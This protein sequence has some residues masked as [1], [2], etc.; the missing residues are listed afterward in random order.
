MFFHGGRLIYQALTCRLF[1]VLVQQQY[2]VT[3][4]QCMALI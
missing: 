1:V 2:L 4:R 3:G